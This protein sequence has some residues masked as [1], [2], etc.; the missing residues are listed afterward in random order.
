MT[1]QYDIE[2]TTRSTA[3]SD[4]YIQMM[5]TMDLKQA[6]K[7]CSQQANMLDLKE[8]GHS[9]SYFAPL[10]VLVMLFGN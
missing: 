10:T 4:I 9:F 2:E 6:C 8:K 1:G 7:T 5:G 3:S